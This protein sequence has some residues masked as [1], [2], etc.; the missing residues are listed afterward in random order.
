MQKSIIK[1]INFFCWFVYVSM[2]KLKH[3]FL[4]KYKEIMKQKTEYTPLCLKIQV[5]FYFL[6]P[7]GISASCK[8]KLLDWKETE[9]S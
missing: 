4:K 8:E 2:N 3:V 6:F 5:A 1:T 9:Q 7:K